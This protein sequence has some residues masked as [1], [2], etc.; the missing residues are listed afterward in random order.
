MYRTKMDHTARGERQKVH[1]KGHSNISYSL[2]SI[3][4]IMRTHTLSWSGLASP[5][6]R[7][8]GSAFLAFL[9]ALTA[10]RSS[11]AFVHHELLGKAVIRHQQPPSSRNLL[12]AFSVDGVN[13]AIISMQSSSIQISETE[14]WRQYVPLVVSLLVITDI[15]LGSP[16]ANAVLSIIRPKEE[17]Q[18]EDVSSASPFQTLFGNNVKAK[19]AKDLKER[20]DSM[21]VAQQALDKAAA[22]TELRKFLDESKSDMEKMRDVQKKLDEQLAAYDKKQLEKDNNSSM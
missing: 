3:T 9:L 14:S 16:A 18:S 2:E 13:D 20:I 21:A 17:G 6:R 7:S 10:C 5:K 22:T 19:P 4:F 15:L 1:V 11:C 8:Q 12:S